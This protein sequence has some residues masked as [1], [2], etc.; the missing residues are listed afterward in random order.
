MRFGATRCCKRAPE[1]D[2][3]AQ[4]RD[5]EMGHRAAAIANE[6]ERAP[7]FALLSGTIQ[8]DC[9]FAIAVAERM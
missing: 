4:H 8:A 1:E 7:G 5:E 6:A 2:A 3:F 9:A